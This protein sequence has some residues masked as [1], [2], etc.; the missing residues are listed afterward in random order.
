MF[1]YEGSNG[2]TFTFLK[3]SMY[4]I[5]ISSIIKSEIKFIYLFSICGNKMCFEWL[6]IGLNF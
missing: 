3:I 5:M 6:L 2:T 1:S 4:S